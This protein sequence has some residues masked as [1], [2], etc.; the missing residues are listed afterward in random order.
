MLKK[1]KKIQT[2]LSTKDT[3]RETLVIWWLR[4]GLPIQGTQVR[5]IVQKDPTRHRQPSPWVTTTEPSLYSP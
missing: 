4:T 1:K 3:L 5:S 2:Q